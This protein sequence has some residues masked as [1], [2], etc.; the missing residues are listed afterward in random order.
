[1][2]ISDPVD[3]GETFFIPYRPPKKKKEAPDS[4]EMERFSTEV[5]SM[6]MLIMSPHLW[7]RNTKMSG[8]KVANKNKNAS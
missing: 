8:K 7:Y 4:I 2:L 3:D 5:A 1:M 6:S